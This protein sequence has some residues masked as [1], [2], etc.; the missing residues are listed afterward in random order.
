MTLKR[1]LV[2]LET[3]YLLIRLPPWFENAGK[4]LTRT[5]KLYL[6]DAGLLAHLLGFDAGGLSSRPADAGPLAETFV[7]TELHKLAPVSSIRPRLFHFRTSAGQEVDVVMENRRKDLV[8]VEVKAGATITAAD[9]KGLR[10]LQEV[11]GRRFACGV[12]LYTGRE[13]LPFGPKLWAVP[14]GA[15]WS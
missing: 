12:A 14:M 1:Y 10:V 5:P 7:V 6:N 2:L 8:G 11:A 13:I 3:L 15:L 4:R 9:F